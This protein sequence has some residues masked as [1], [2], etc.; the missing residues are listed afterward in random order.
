MNISTLLLL[1]L[2]FTTLYST[3]ADQI[4]L[5]N[6]LSATSE[7]NWRTQ[8][9]PDD[10]DG[11]GWVEETVYSKS[12]N[13][14]HQ[15]YS[16]CYSDPDIENWLLL[17]RIERGE[18]SLLE[19][20]FGFTIVKCG[21]V[22]S[23][24][25]TCKETLKLYAV[26]LD[27]EESLPQNFANSTRWEIIDTLVSNSEA[28]EA[29]VQQKHVA[30]YNANK[31]SVYF[32]LRNTGACASIMF[33][34]VYY[35]FCP[36]TKNAFLQL[37]RTVPSKDFVTVPAKC[38]ENA[39]PSATKGMTTSNAA[40]PAPTYI[41]KSDGKWHQV[42]DS[43][44]EC[45]A[46]YIPSLKSG[47]CTACGP[48]TYKANKG[49]GECQLCPRHSNS[50]HA[51]SSE[52]ECITGY[53]RPA[54]E[55]AAH[56]CKKKQQFANDNSLDV[57]I[58]SSEDYTSIGLK[59]SL[60]WWQYFTTNHQAWPWILLCLISVLLL[61]CVLLFISRYSTSNRKQMSD[62][63]ALDSYKQDTITPDYGRSL[64]GHVAA[65]PAGIRRNTNVPLIPTY[66]THNRGVL[67]TTSRYRPYV[68]PTTYED[69]NQALEEFTNEI[70]PENVQVTRV[71]GA[72]EFGEVCCGRLTV[73]DTY[74]QVQQHVVAVK[75]LLPGSASK[76]KLD[77][78]TEASIMGQFEH[79]NVIR[80][81][82]V[83]TKSEPVMILTE[84][85]LN[86]SLDQFL[87]MNDN[88]TI[89][90]YQLVKMLHGIASGMKYLTDKGYVHRDL[91]A[92]NVLVDD[93]LT[94][95]IADFGL[96]RGLRNNSG[97]QEYTTQT[98]G[99]IPIRW[100]APEAI[101]YH[102]YTTQSDVWSFGVVMWEV[103]SFGERPYWD[104]SNHKVMQ[105]VQSGFRLPCPM[106]SPPQLYSI[107]LACW[108]ADRHQ[109]PTFAMLLS[110]L[111]NFLS[112]MEFFLSQS[113]Q[114]I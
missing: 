78:L 50:H 108:Q 63:D 85:M 69:P 46:G 109:R 37:P 53:M 93:R 27:K 86:G 76:A 43:K 73:E 49:I 94:C 77:F 60:S 6:T 34:K 29:S 36:E 82:G 84:Y 75:T 67:G 81:L 24:K 22:P 83:V 48:G 68:D 35:N 88:G 105:E 45:N 23:P 26:Q 2:S 9:N 31:S 101:N 99:K 17:P 110:Q 102:K 89:E 112:E 5:L 30:S 66:G 74:G 57:K 13:V 106:D 21:S 87:K 65:F 44:C 97:E 80:L 42:S 62:L 15:V 4:N 20:E 104:W 91:A 58:E 40:V 107:M 32:A 12:E 111:Q 72:G 51:G 19:L 11:E 41:C 56:S 61:C 16:I 96:S 39:S 71:I 52:C 64:G 18:A 100:T 98:G 114:C 1:L 38:V 54:N 25:G 3:R 14:N 59:E 28:D 33:A 7:L 10:K 8:S 92:R 90:M 79:E 95:K 47:L 70:R 55:S 113:F 103:C